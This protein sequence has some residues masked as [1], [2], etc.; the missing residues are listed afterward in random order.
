MI[1]QVRT[2]CELT[3]KHHAW[4][5]SCLNLVAAE[6][7]TSPLVEALL[8]SDFSRRYSCE[9][10]YAGD[11][12]FV[13]IYEI[14]REL[15]KSLFGVKYVELRPISG[16]LTVLA[17]IAGLTRPGD[18]IV[19]VDPSHGGYPIRIADWAGINSVYHP[20]DCQ[21]MNIRIEEAREK[22]LEV[23]PALVVFGASEFLF[24]HPVSGLAQACHEVGATIYYDGS[25]VMGLIAGAQFQ[26][27]L[28]EGADVLAGSTHK[29]LPG[30]QRGV[31]LTNNQTIYERT[32]NVLDSPP[33]L[34]S[35]YHL[36]TLVAM[37][38]A[39]AECAEFGR[40]FAS[41]IVKNA[42][43]LAR[44]LDR[45]GV[46]VLAGEHG[47]TMSHQVILENDGFAS[48]K[49]WDIS[50]KLE[51]CGI[52][53]DV[54]VRLG[55]QE[56][57]RLGMQEVEMEETASLIADVIRDRRPAEAV[58]DDVRVLASNYRK[59]LFSFQDGEE[60]YGLIGSVLQHAIP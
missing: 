60:A 37:G 5:R 59:I 45:E 20:F 30:P 31:I 18:T 48:P 4:R 35:C 47:Y 2:I 24:P 32:G 51:K 29:T 40:Q 22:I 27:P 17:C 19:T 38:V 10:V 8:A 41:Q 56:V 53:S 11:K 3:E 13:H 43:A 1:E 23:R 33:F 58:R 50:A 57:T 55:V 12:Y 26:D 9:G 7:A 49:G 42:Q 25:H 15:A 6:C 36:N 34:Q 52:L 44:A 21:R 14:V 54:G 39:L 28:S 16:N 46:P